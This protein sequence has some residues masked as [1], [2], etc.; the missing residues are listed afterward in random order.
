MFLGFGRKIIPL[1]LL[2]KVSKM[3]WEWNRSLVSSIKEHSGCEIRDHCS[4]SS[5]KY[6]R[7]ETQATDL[8]FSFLLRLCQ[9]VLQCKAWHT[10]STA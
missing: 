4:I 10:I 6:T 1:I 7:K 8:T 2:T 9:I 3:V 5:S